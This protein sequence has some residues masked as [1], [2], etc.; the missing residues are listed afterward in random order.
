MPTP[1]SDMQRAAPARR[2]ETFARVFREVRP[3]RRQLLGL[4]LLSALG[5]ALVLAMP[6]P[7]KI[8]VDSI[9]G[10]HP[11]PGFLDPF[12]PGAEGSGTLLLATA[13]LFVAISV[14]VQLQEV[15][16]ILLSTYTG[17]KVSLRFRSKLFRH[18]QRLSLGY[19]D[20]RGTMDS[21]YRLQWD[22][23][24]LQHIAVEAAIP[25]V[26][27]T[28][29]VIGM[30]VVTALID[31]QLA[32]VA[33]TVSPIL[34]VVLRVYGARL[35]RQWHTAK[36]IESSAFSVVQE[37]LG[38]LRVVKAFA[39]EERE[40]ERFVERSTAGMRAQLRLALT[41]SALSVAVGMT[42]A[43]GT[44]VVLYVGVKRVQ[45]GA[46]TLGELLLV[47]TYLAQLY[48]PLKEIAGKVGDIQ[49]S[50][51]SAERVFALLDESPDIEDTPGA[52]PI[53]RAR[54]AVA[55]E[56]ISFGYGAERPVLRDVSLVV[57][58]G[59][60][61]GITG[62][63]GAG[64]TTLISLLARFYDPTAGRILLDGVDLREYRLADVRN[65]FA[66]VLQEPVLF[67][68]S[69]GENIAYARPDATHEQV[70]AAARAANADEFIRGLP[71]GYDSLVG[72]RGVQLSGGERQRI[73]LARAFLK[74]A[75]ILILDEPTSSVDTETERKIV[76][77]MER[78]VE[79]RT[80]FMI[81]HRQ[82][83]L[84]RCD[85]RFEVED[86]RVRPGPHPGRRKGRVRRP[87]LALRG[88]SG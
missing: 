56:Q 4:F 48:Q 82:S 59:A 24:A 60:T 86:G 50:A 38:A 33:A 20:S 9:L 68:S 28:L 43:L 12:L 3:F 75:P 31:W 79:G 66:I 15:A 88:S 84:E 81:A 42:I 25:L 30:I 55:F 21:N 22:A 17:Q 65:Q 14:V 44:A 80:A 78:L 36:E 49:A 72:E 53:R 70:A 16:V 71:Q 19:H 29:T 11:V 85:V 87:S 7:L 6:I 23:P 27:S 69:V 61:V 63:T 73:A 74:D 40:R 76:E 39:A 58:P 1:Y 35:R 51:A 77:A 2:V 83:T 32:L 10:S 52:L 5:G 45:A 57:A 37:V 54:G 34:V 64:K 62:A 46:L 67:S 47:M 18:L 41:E 8:A 13:L 26:T